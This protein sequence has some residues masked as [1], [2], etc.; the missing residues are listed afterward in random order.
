MIH[1]MHL[2]PTHTHEQ[3]CDLTLNNRAV[4][5][6]GEQAEDENFLRLLRQANPTFVMLDYPAF[7]GEEVSLDR[8]FDWID[9]LRPN[10]VVV[11]D[12]R[13][14]GP[15]TVEFAHLFYEKF[16]DAEGFP[17]H[18]CE[19]L[20]VPQGET[21]AEWYICLDELLQL[22]PHR[23]ALVEEAERF[24][25]LQVVGESSVRPVPGRVGLL[26]FLSEMLQLREKPIHFLG[27]SEDLR[28]LSFSE[29]LFPGWVQSC[30]TAKGVVLSHA[31]VVINPTLVDPPIYPGRGK[32]YFQQKLHW[33]EKAIDTLR[34]NVATLDSWCVERR[35]RLDV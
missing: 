35:T 6:V 9:K 4:M 26:F 23:V 27:L 33:G 8:Y 2:A 18:P 1:L 13:S 7:E 25:R 24:V 14:N 5:V 34:R 28:E 29:R 11:P 21:F 17:E 19:L 15:K 22:K 16:F 31:G 30:D 3:V 32:N 20:V 12:V 10:I